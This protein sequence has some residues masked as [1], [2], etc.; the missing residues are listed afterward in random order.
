MTKL[1]CEPEDRIG[2]SP[3]ATASAITLGRNSTLTL[4]NATPG[5]AFLGLGSDGAEQ[6][7]GHEWFLGIDWDSKSK[8]ALIVFCECF[9][10]SDGDWDRFT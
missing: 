9:V 1:L 4:N 10:W 3:A 7:M 5:S 8:K 6:I 2:F